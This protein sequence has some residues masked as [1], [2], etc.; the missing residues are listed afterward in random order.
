MMC[1]QQQQQQQQQQNT[2]MRTCAMTHLLRR[3]AIRNAGNVARLGRVQHLARGISVFGALLKPLVRIVVALLRVA[4][5]Q[6]PRPP[7]ARLVAQVDAVEQIRLVDDGVASVERDHLPALP[8]RHV[9]AAAVL[10]TIVGER[11][12]DGAGSDGGDE[13]NRGELASV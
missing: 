13:A 5:P 8:R 2:T 9:E 11:D 12:D 4:V 1:T 6:D 3:L 10:G 7:L